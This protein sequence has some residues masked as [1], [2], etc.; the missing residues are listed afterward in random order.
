MVY[1][2]I[3]AHNNKP[4]VLQV[5]RCLERQRYGDLEVLLVDDGSTDG[6]G[7]EVR[8]RFPRVRVLQG[9]GQL[10]WTGAN[11]LGVSDVTERA[12]TGDFILLLNNDVSMDD[13]YVGELVKCSE[14]L[15]RA[16][17][18]STIVDDERRDCMVAGLRL[19]RRL[20]VTEQTDAAAIRES[21]YDDQVDV[22]PG[23]GTLVPLEVFRRIGTFN[24]RRLPHYGADYE[25]SIRARRAGFRLAVSHRAK[26]Y[27]KLRI[28]GLYPPDRPRISFAEC[29]RLLCSRKSTANLRY[30]LNYVWLCSEPGDKWRNTLSHGVG[31]LLDTVGKTVVGFPLQACSRLWLKG[32]RTVRVS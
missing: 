29:A 27:A 26:V 31:L 30:Y 9:D 14:H 24:R 25:F 19:D 4:E 28:T 16:I 1:A 8:R 22:L 2:L 18:G 6:T 12:R 17:V 21:E 11:I 32:T 13:D 10:W 20:R 5:L 23:R 7:E 3:P 15:G